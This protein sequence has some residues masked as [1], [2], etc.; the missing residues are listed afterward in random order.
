MAIDGRTSRWDE[1]RATRRTEL[2]S[3]ALRAIRVQ[4]PAIGM[5]DIAVRAGTSKTVLYRHFGDRAGLHEAVVESVHT[6]IRNGVLAALEQSDAQDVAHMMETLAGTYLNLVEKDP[7]IYRF[8]MNGPGSGETNP[9]GRVPA[10]I[11]DAVAQLLAERLSH[12][13]RQRAHTWGYGLVG[14]IQASA[15]AWMDTEAEARPSR[16]DVVLDICAAFSH[17]FSDASVPAASA[18]TT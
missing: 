11:A 12:V 14:F 9:A 15:D 17:A 16:E 7:A 3:H 10:A 18:L 5:E 4:G 6:Y 13:S 1:H 8:V 2:I